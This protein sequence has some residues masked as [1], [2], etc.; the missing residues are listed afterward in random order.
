MD[1]I[2]LGNRYQI[3]ELIGIG[4][5]AKV[6]RATDT[7]LQR[8][9]AV[10][11][12]KEQYAEDEDFLKKFS[13][14][15]QSA[16][17]LTHANIV[18]VYDI[19]Q[20]IINGKQIY[21]IVME[22][23]EGQTLKDLIDDEGYLSNHDLTDFSIQIAQALKSAHNNNIVHRDIK[24]QNILIDNY[25]LLKV[26][27]FGIARVSTNATIT[28]TSSILGTVHYISPEQA[29]G[30]FVDE[31][32]DLYSLG[33][34]MYEMATGKVPFDADNSVGIAVMHIQ[35]EPIRPKKLNPKLTDHLDRIIMKLLSKEPINRFTNAK[36]LIDALEDEN[37]VF[38]EE[39]I[40]KE[41]AQ[42]PIV[43]PD[44][45]DNTELI[46]KEDIY[47]KEIS[48]DIDQEKGEAVYVSPPKS[49]KP[50]KPKKKKT[51]IWPLA[52]LAMILLAAVFYFLN[53]DDSEKI[54]IPTVL[55]LT[56]K[57]AVEQLQNRGLKA[58]IARYAESD[59]YEVGKVMEQDP[60]PKSIVEPG[61][62]V[63]LVI[64]QGREVEVP[65]V[66]NMTI[67]QAEEALASK[68]L[69]LGRTNT[70]N[71]K[72]IEKDLVISQNPG[73]GDSVQVG[74]EINLTISLGPEE[75]DIIMVSVPDIVGQTQENA[76]AIINN[77]QMIVRNITSEYSDT[78]EENVVISQSISPNTQVA[79]QSQIDFVISLGKDPEK[80]N[81][82]QNNA[83]A[84]N[85]EFSLTPPEGKDSFTVKIYKVEEDGTTS[86]LLYNQVHNISEV[87]ENNKINLSFKS[88]EGTKVQIY[89]DDVAIGV[90]EVKQ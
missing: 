16:A 89:Y 43:V 75:P 48:E 12:L 28:Y 44:K 6:Y 56:E 54:E 4:G 47:E 1:N 85:V 70:E 21:Y 87:N 68:G 60:S 82:D 59:S 11:V 19:G 45:Y 62:T 7:L 64:S 35:D 78:V 58:N 49:N 80:E 61:T 5:M 31:K 34:V 66:S 42:I 32:S 65:D 24:P 71:S 88:V 67:E 29:K 9:V 86:D 2:L 74:T 14:E 20:D 3:I 55:N 90:Y 53:K 10:K 69:K 41:T 46:N 79:E 13:N 22:H 37:Y 17:K 51:R 27:D 33:V 18:S 30:K 72:N 8:E 81:K 83:K 84:V 63:N 76:I 73:S 77:S 39:I 50:E 36:E 40:E 38:D 57:E 52:F 25:G 26:T 23:V 15:A